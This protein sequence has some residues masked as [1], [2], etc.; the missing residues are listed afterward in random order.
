MPSIYSVSIYQSDH[1]N[2]VATSPLIISFPQIVVHKAVARS[3]R[4][5]SDKVTPFLSSK[6]KRGILATFWPTSIGND[7]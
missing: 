4:L 1:L 3:D 2:P 6:T 5:F 7:F